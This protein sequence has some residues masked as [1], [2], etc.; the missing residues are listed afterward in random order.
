M[1]FLYLF[2]RRWADDFIGRH[3][4]RVARFKYRIVGLLDYIVV[5]RLTLDKGRG[6]ER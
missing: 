6:S 2:L 4:Y 1:A 5:L 3:L